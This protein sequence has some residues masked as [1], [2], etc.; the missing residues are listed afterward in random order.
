MS[1]LDSDVMV[2]GYPLGLTGLTTGSGS[3]SSVK[4]DPGRNIVFVQTD[5]T[6]NPGNSGGPLLN[7]QGQ[8]IGV[9]TSKIT[10]GEVEDFGLAVSANTVRLY[11]KRLKEGEVITS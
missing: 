6:I 7:M 2:I 11:L 3:A 4:Y 8:V 5:S 9:V 1:R 10:G